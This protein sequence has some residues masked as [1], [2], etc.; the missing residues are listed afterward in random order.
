MCRLQIQEERE[1]IDWPGYFSYVALDMST[2]RIF[3]FALL[4]A[5]VI[6]LYAPLA[7]FPFVQDD[8]TMIHEY[9]FRSPSSILLD[10]LSPAGK[11]FYRPAGSLYCWLVYS[12]FGLH[13][14]GF[15]LLALLGLAL[16]S[17]LVVA[18]AWRL[19]E[20]QCVAWGS[21]FLY[22]AASNIHIDPQMW[23]VGAFD[24][25]GTLCGLF[26]IEAFLRKRFA[27]SALWFGVALGF[28]ESAAMLLCVLTAWTLLNGRDASGGKTKFRQ[29][30]D[31]LKWHI[32][33]VL[34]FAC[35]RITG[36]SLFALPDAHPYAAR[37]IGSHTVANFQLYAAWGLQAVLP[38]KSFAFSENGAL[39]LL[40]VATGALVLVFIAG[41]RYYGVRDKTS[42]RMLVVPAFLL[43]WVL[44]M[45][46]PSLALKHQVN[47]YYLTA[48]LPPLAVG[49]MLL[50]RFALLSAG[51]SARFIVFA[52]AAF[53]AVNL[54][55]GTLSLYHRAGLGT[56]DG[57]HAS[58]RDGDN[59][60]IRKASTVR[61]VWKPLLAALPSIPSHSLLILEDV[62]TGCF[63]DRFGP[64]VW[65]GDST[66]LL[67]DSVPGG[68]DSLGMLH[69][70]I[71]AGEPW[72]RPAQPA[73]IAFPASRAV[74]VRY[75]RGGVELL[76][77]G[78]RSE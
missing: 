43:A 54:I 8:W 67:T 55:D 48:V 11:L 44:L 36:A 47:R 21:G 29:A 72:K 49:T 61:D 33:A 62:D 46:V 57:V 37:F 45:L 6:L 22:A 38:L 7:Q 10:V 1:G 18:V 63:A 56:L 13:P 2:S 17:F 70:T 68:P 73:V 4:A 58:G 14:I 24:I 35:A 41:I 23:L 69:A 75:V 52:T 19:T 40:F 39:M 42:G 78:K 71:G 51:R 26:C 27:I 64:Q 34:A 59:H 12:L 15:H 5:S 3:L 16:S 28:K 53:A 30:F 25:G 50:F 74:H 31:M 66:L 32:A 20:D 65:Y 76:S 60:L 77:A 9:T